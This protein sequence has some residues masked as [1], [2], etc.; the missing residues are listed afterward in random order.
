MRLSTG[1]DRYV[2]AHSDRTFLGGYTGNWLV[3]L[4]GRGTGRLG[5]RG[6][7]EYYFSLNTFL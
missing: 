6:E 3:L 5:Y 2:Y 4:T 7:G 1:N